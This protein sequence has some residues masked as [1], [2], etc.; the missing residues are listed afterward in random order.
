MSVSWAGSRN[1]NYV[2]YSEHGKGSPAS[3][4]RR[5]VAS[6]LQ[7]GLDRLPSEEETSAQKSLPLHGNVRDAG[8]YH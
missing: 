5:S 1:C 8:Y 2:Q 3:I 4:E 6:I 7:Q